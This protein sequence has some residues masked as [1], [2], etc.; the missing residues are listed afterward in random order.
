MKQ[1][2]TEVAIVITIADFGG[3]GVDLDTLRAA[4]KPAGAE[5]FDDWYEPERYIDRK[6][7]PTTTALSSGPETVRVTMYIPYFKNGTNNYIKFRCLDVAGNGFAESEEY[8]VVVDVS[9]PDLVVALSSPAN[10]SGLRTTTPTLEWEQ[11]KIP[12]T[13]NKIIYHVYLSDDKK[14]LTQLDIQGNGSE[15]VLLSVVDGD[16]FELAIAETDLASLEANTTYYWTVI[17]V[18][19]T[20]AGQLVFGSCESGTWEF[21]VFLG[22]AGI[23]LSAE[24]NS[25]Q[26]YSGGTATFSV[27]IRNIGLARDDFSLAFSTPGGLILK[28]SRSSVSLPAGGA[29]HVNLTVSAP[30]SH[31]GGNYTITV[32]GTGLGSGAETKLGLGV[33]IIQ[34]TDQP[35]DDD[36]TK[37]G[38]RTSWGFIIMLILIMLLVLIATVYHYIYSKR[39]G[40]KVEGDAGDTGSPVMVEQTV[41]PVAEIRHEHGSEPVPN[42]E[43]TPVAEEQTQ[44]S[45]NTPQP[46]IEKSDDNQNQ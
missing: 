7:E 2:S 3:S 38:Q 11:R 35:D 33:K 9:I 42:A 6:T 32:T 20:G 8:R 39:S 30:E 5:A 44:A 41:R 26:L 17:P 1:Y 34:R 15:A 21:M 18:M 29:E 19:D 46:I 31:Q 45:E 43:G 24:P 36:I 27:R 13:S 25:V 10:G 4:V 22:K 14:D 23:S 37:E 16:S 40:R 28:L 12:Q